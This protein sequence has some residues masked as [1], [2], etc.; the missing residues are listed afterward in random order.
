MSYTTEILTRALLELHPIT[1]SPPVTVSDRADKYVLMLICRIQREPYPDRI[2]IAA[3]MANV[4]VTLV[5]DQG[6]V[7]ILK[8]WYGPTLP[9][10]MTVAGK[11][12]VLQRA[13]ELAAV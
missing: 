7:D 12:A 9:K 13:A 11:A 4:G 2:I 5:G 6:T 1:E 10:I 3:E 8:D